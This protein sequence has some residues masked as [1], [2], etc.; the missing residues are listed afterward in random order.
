MLVTALF[1]VLKSG[2]AYLPVDPGYPAKRIAFI[3]ADA[4]P[5]LLLTDAATAGGLPDTPVPTVVLDDGVLDDGS[6]A[7][8]IAAHP[9]SPVT[10]ADRHA[11]LRPCNQAYVIYVHL[12]L[13]RHAEGRRGHAQRNLEPAAVDAA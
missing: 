1:A 12:R 11:P 3:L 10:D 2:A 13:H 9:A 4:A 8:A 6:I 5:A 7:K